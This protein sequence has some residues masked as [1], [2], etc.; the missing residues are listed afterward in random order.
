MCAS[1]NLLQPP[2][3]SSLFQ[4]FASKPCS[5]TPLAFVLPF[6][7]ETKLHSHTKQQ[8][9]LQFMFLNSRPKDKWF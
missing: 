8:A 9:K 2:V 1:C 4:T 5:Q 7:S 6:K 3:T